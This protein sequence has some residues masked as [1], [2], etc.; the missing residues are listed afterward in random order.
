MRPTEEEIFIMD[1]RC[2]AKGINHVH[3]TTYCLFSIILRFWADFH[4]SQV[5][6]L[7]REIQESI[8]FNISAVI[9]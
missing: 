5:R 2:L 1:I 8:E 3:A 4:R 7:T 9:V 6:V